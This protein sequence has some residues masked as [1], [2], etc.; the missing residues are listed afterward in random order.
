M[1]AEKEFLLEEI[2]ERL[3]SAQG[4][5]LTRYQNMPANL[6]AA[7]RAELLKAGSKFFGLKKRMFMKAMQEQM[8]YE[9]Q[10]LEGH[11]G[12]V[13]VQ[14]DFVSAAKAVL[15]FQK[16]NGE[17]L[18]V[19]GGI[20]EGKKC[21]S[22]EVKEISDLPSLDVMRAQIIGTLIAPMTHTLSTVQAMLASIIYCADNKVKKENVT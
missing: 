1:L 5:I 22:Q 19:L 8:P 4:V 16:S 7:F 21:T 13:L 18:S 20:F 3:A 14:E 9:L 6:N 15:A 11:V 2:K 12:V 17:M 10:E